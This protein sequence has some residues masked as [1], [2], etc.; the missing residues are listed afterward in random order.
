MSSSAGCNDGQGNIIPA[1]GLP[2]LIKDGFRLGWAQIQ[3][4]FLGQQAEDFEIGLGAHGFHGTLQALHFAGDVGDG[5]VLF[6]GGRGGEYDVGTLR[7]FG[8]EHLLHYDK[9]VLRR[10]V[11]ALQRIRADDPEYVEIGGG[12]DF[13]GGEAVRGIGVIA[14][15]Q[16]WDEPHIHRAAGV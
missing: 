7:G 16:A 5:A 12:Q 1:N 14:G 8:E 4:H 13:V 11:R 3:T 6:I 9:R 2:N 15:Q 10:Q